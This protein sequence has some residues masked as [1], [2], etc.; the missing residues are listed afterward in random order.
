MDKDKAQKIHDLPEL[1]TLQQVSD[2]LGCSKWT[3]RKWDNKGKLKAVRIGLKEKI[4]GH[5]RYR[6]D[7]IIKILNEG[8]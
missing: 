7:D 2:L 1:L 3:L 6:K 4:G 8:M 5:R